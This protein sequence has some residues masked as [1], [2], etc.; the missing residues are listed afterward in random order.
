MAEPSPALNRGPTSGTYRAITEP[1]PPLLAS[2]VL[3]E[4]LAPLQPGRVACRLWLAGIAVALIALGLAM[5]LGVGVPALRVDAATL[6]FSAAGALAAIAV[7]PFPYALR[8][9]LALIVGVALMA[10][11]L[12]G[13]GPLAGIAVDGSLARMVARLVAMTALPAALLFRSRYRA[14][15]RAR[16]V[17]AVALVAAL[18][19]VALEIALGLDG[20]A[21]AVA[22]AAAAASTAIVLTSLFGFM[23]QGT[24]GWSALWAVLILIVLPVEV[25]LRHFTLADL[26]TGYLTYPATAVGI[27]CTAALTSFGLYQLLATLFAPEARRL[28][29]TPQIRIEEA[30]ESGATPRSSGPGA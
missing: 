22:R 30:A 9:G 10:V 25:S 4:E 26:D 7:L 13:A 17:L 5:R 3:R 28:S 1:K 2:E 14:Y 27:V 8:A 11:G 6:S 19:F 12:R 29:M 20:T 16:A 23:G 24:T 21:P 18:P 15:R